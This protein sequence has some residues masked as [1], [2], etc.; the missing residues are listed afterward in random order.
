MIAIE[1]TR[2]A[3]DKFEILERH[4]FEVTPDQVEETVLNPDRV[5]PQ[6]RGK[7]IAQR[8]IT[9]RH[10]LRVVYQVVGETCVVI[11][12]YPGLKERYEN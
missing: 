7:F 8:G 12:F 4:D 6:L 10:V 9:A 11:T 2:H 3:R 1:Y 5:I